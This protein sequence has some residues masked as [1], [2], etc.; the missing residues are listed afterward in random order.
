MLYDNIS[1]QIALVSLPK[2][3]RFTKQIYVIW[4]CQTK[5]VDFP[6]VVSSGYYTS[7]TLLSLLQVKAVILW[8]NTEASMIDWDLKH[9][10]SSSFQDFLQLLLRCQHSVVFRAP[11]HMLTWAAWH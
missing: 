3:K 7:I 6:G 9:F 4:L 10:F 2:I 8:I 1:Y 11:F 5:L